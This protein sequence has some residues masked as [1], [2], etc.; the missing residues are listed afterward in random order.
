MPTPKHHQKSI[1]KKKKKISEIRNEIMG[2]R[3][4]TKNQWVGRLRF[5]H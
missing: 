1:L 4:V 2:K 3:L 5:S